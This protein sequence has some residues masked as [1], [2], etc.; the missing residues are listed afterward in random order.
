[1][2][3]TAALGLLAATLI[4]PPPAANPQALPP[5]L[6]LTEYEAALDTLVAPKAISFEYTV[7]QAGEL[8]MEQQHR[9]YRSGTNERDETLTVNDEKV[10]PPAVRIFRNRRDRY[11]VTN[12][13]PRA[14]AYTFKYVGPHTAGK[15]VEYLFRTARRVPAPFSV[16]EVTIDGS[17]FLPVSISFRTVQN[18]LTGSGVIT[19]A[20]SGRYWLPTSATASARSGPRLSR[21]RI[22]FTAYAFPTSLPESTFGVARPLPLPPPEEEPLE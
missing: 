10:V 19:Y 3:R 17:R 12:L 20:P 4:A 6:V 9:V 22:L 1:M 13:A 16:F 7:E 21:E 18:G 5:R 8:D 11:A 15:H 2:N 14:A